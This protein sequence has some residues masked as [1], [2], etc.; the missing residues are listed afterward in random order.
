MTTTT[1]LWHDY[2]TFGADTRGDRPVQF[3]G[4]RTD[5]EL[6]PI[7]EPLMVYCRPAAD[8][9][10]QPEACLITGITPQE[11]LQKG[12]SENTFIQQ[13]VE[14]LG[15]PGS[16]GVGYNSLRFDDEIT[17][18]TLYRNLYD[19][20][21]REWK[22]GN[23]RWDIIDL[24]RLTR[25]LRPEGIEWPLYEDGR[26]SMRL[27]HLTVANGIE[28]GMAHDALAD[29][30][31]TIAMARLVKQKQPRLYHYVFSQRDKQSVRKLLNLGHPT[32]LLHISSMYPSERGNLALILPLVRHPTNN[33]G[34]IVYDLSVD[35]TPLLTLSPEEIHQRL[36]TPREAMAE[37]V[38]RIP[39]KTVHLNKC[40][41]LAPLNTL[42][43]ESQTRLQIDLQQQREHATILTSASTF[44]EN[45]AKA[46]LLHPFRAEQDPDRMIYSG[47]FGEEDRLQMQQIHRLSPEALSTQPFSFQ[48][49]RLGEM[50][51]R[52]RARNWPHSLTAAEQQKWSRFCQH[53]LLDAD[54]GGTIHYEK[55]Q[56]EIHQLSIEH[57]DNPK[58]LQLLQALE[59]YGS[60]LIQESQGS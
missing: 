11:A 34:V 13:V 52:Y 19:P 8:Y 18:N 23:S 54:G 56:S 57:A 42:N 6:N 22:W 36:F 44:A 46:H 32:P 2:E 30:Y 43:E 39:V 59:Q 48:D 38:E 20:Y 33:N 40:P 9:L 37:G 50:L 16:C 35:P 10:P 7:G 58:K 53:R 28:H 47:F 27:E 26:P 29:V 45:I 1:L 4:I 41:V 49:P 31:A 21:E 14:E 12:E 17:R 15:A 60:M 3:A 51:F 25:A 5:L 24:L 55:F